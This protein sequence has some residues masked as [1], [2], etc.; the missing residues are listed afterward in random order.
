MSHNNH[1]LNYIGDG[2]SGDT[3]TGLTGYKKMGAQYSLVNC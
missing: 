2:L 3:L 1:D